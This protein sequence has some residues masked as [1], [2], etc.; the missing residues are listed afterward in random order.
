MVR[1]VDVLRV[2]RFRSVSC[3]LD[4]VWFKR[5]ESMD[6]LELSCLRMRSWRFFFLLRF[7][8]VSYATAFGRLFWLLAPRHL[9]VLSLTLPST[10]LDHFVHGCFDELGVV[11]DL[12]LGRVAREVL[13]VC[14]LMLLRCMPCAAFVES[15]V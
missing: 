5:S 15:P 2:L 10:R 8:A 13:T 9:S 1:N 12:T 11:H 14:T 6:A 7:A 4:R 3:H